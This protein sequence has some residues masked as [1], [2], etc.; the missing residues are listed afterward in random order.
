M[1]AADPT[2]EAPASPPVDAGL[3]TKGMQVAILVTRSKALDANAKA[4][5]QDVQTAFAEAR[6]RGI[7]QI[8]LRRPTASR[9]AS[10]R[11]SAALKSGPPTRTT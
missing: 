2:P 4:V 6:Q 8:E 7:T 3:A 11:S 5:R 9:S 1:T 10:S